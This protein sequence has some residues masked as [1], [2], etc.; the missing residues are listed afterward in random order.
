MG[1]GRDSLRIEGE[2]G[3]KGCGTFGNEGGVYRIRDKLFNRKIFSTLTEARILIEQWRM[4]C[5]Q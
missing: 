4:N 5:N 3:T 2:G 1:L